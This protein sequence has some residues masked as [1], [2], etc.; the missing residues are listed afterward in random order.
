[1]VGLIFD[2]NIHQLP[3]R[4]LYREDLPR[5]ISVHSEGIREVLQSVYQT[6]ELL[7]ELG[8]TP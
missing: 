1:V 3:N 7:E 2:G 4:F 8:G 6:K 5:S